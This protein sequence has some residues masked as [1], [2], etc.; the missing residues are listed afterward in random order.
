M[1]GLDPGRKGLHFIEAVKAELGTDPRDSSGE[2]GNR[3]W[4]LGGGLTGGHSCDIPRSPMA[5]HCR[6]VCSATLGQVG[7][8]QE[9]RRSS[10]KVRPS[11]LWREGGKGRAWLLA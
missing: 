1:R 6:C 4:E 8:G 7:G 3:E 11:K 9:A 5:S 10:C 2:S